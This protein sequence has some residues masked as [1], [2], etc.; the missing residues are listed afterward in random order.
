MLPLP[1]RIFAG[2]AQ[3][4]CMHNWTDPAIREARK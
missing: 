1:L 3:L 2:I 4:L